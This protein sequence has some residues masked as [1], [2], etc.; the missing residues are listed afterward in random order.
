MAPLG[1]RAA[2]MVTRRRSIET[3]GG[4]LM[5]RWFQVREGEITA[6]VGAMDNAGALTALFIGS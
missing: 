3:A 4:A 2:E 5:G 6:V 1:G